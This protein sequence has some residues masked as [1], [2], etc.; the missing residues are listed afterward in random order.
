MSD[1]GEMSYPELLVALHQ[2]VAT[3]EQLSDS[4]GRVAVIACYAIEGV[5]GVGLTLRAGGTGTTVAYS[6]D[7]APQ[8]DDAQYEDDTGP[9]LDS[10]REQVTI[11]V[12]RVA[13]EAS[14]WP[15]YVRT[16]ERL[17]IRSSLSLPLR[18]P[19]EPAV[20]ALNFYASPEDAFAGD[21]VAVAEMFAAQASVAVTNAQVYWQARHLTEH[22]TK[23]L[24]SRDRIGQAKGI[25][26]R[27][28]GITGDEAFERLRTLS[29]QRNIKVSDLADEVIWTGQLPDGA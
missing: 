27:S 12:P 9:C 13:D 20:G 11:N 15:S 18:S 1:Y 7:P 25:L 22:L 6:G 2:L 19:G 5:D 4:L 26:M 28:H 23:A 17:G 24:D 14:R 16:A 29:Q 21:T 10:F 3:E 8:L